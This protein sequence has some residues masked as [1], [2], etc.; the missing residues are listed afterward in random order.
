M[1]TEQKREPIMVDGFPYFVK[2]WNHQ[3]RVIKAAA[4]VP[5][6][7]LFFEQ[8]TGKTPATV[9]ILRYK[10]MAH[11][12]PL[13]TLVLCPP[14]VC[15]NWRREFYA[16]SKLGDLVVVLKGSG[17]KRLELLRKGIEKGKTIFVTNYESM[18][19]APLVG[20]LHNWSPE[21]LIADE[22][23]RCKSPQSKRAKQV[24]QL[25]D[26]TLYRYILSG[27]PILNSPMDAFQQFRI[28][29]RGATFGCNFFVFRTKYFYDKNANMP[30]HKH[31][32]DWRPRPGSFDELNKLIY[33]KAMRVEKSECLDLPP[34]V[35]QTIPVEMGAKQA[36]AYEAMFDDFVAFLGERACT[37]QLA[38]TKGLRLQQ[39]VSGFVRFE[40]GGEESFEDNPRAEALEE[41]LEDIAPAQKV[42]VWAVFK[43]NYRVI[44]AICEKLGLGYVELTGDTKAKDRQPNI[45]RFQS[46]PTCRVLIGNPEAGGV[47]CNLTAAPVSI[48][49]SRNFKLE[50][51]LQAEARNH[52]GGSEVHEKITRI[53]LVAAET[54]DE[55]VVEALERK[56]NV[57]DLIL[58]WGR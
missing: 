2:P 39:I 1:S 8:G 3:L 29:D 49:Y 50:N 44:R 10:C 48:F 55:K 43:E 45:D 51:D 28:L 57:A 27:T 35:R 40:D 13:R 7:A 32:P 46:D 33:R 47:G 12:R 41:L 22:S 58:A 17:K 14:V 16:H 36:A 20:E 56:Q 42:I 26:R 18:Q 11:K 5:E 25:A 37:A 30:P 9:N 24:A 23:Q 31:F 21:V 53:D 6:F 38:I 15:E 34:L 19:M 4:P 52:R 54:I